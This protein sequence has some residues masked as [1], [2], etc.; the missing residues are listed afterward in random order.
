MSN[1]EQAL[2]RTIAYGHLFFQPLTLAEVRRYLIRGASDAPAF[3][4][5]AQILAAYRSSVVLQ[6]QIAYEGGFFYLK[7]DAGTGGT[8][9][10][11]AG[12]QRGWRISEQKLRRARKAAALFKYFPFVRYIGVANR[13][14]WH[15]AREE[16]DIDLFV[17]ACSGRL[18][19]VRA[20]VTGMAA[21]L[22]WRPTA[23]LSADK[24][25]LSFY[26]SD[27]ALGIESLS[28]DDRDIHFAFW[29][30]QVLPLVDY[31]QTSARFFSLN[32]PWLSRYFYRVEHE[33]YAR[34]VRAQPLLQRFFERCSVR[35]VA[36]ALERRLCRW[37]TK[38]LDQKRARLSAARA[39]DVVYSHQVI[40]L[41]WTDRRRQV[42]DRLE[43]FYEAHFSSSR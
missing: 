31:A 16:S 33:H 37:Q 39:T 29:T 43:S 26:V 14:G 36:D 9:A 40:K 7:Q 34:T 41:H 15:V 38:L 1:I 22:R 19:L 4:T 2:A 11:Q 30:Y 6:E 35:F 32:A 8:A 28:L 42:R 18:W 27:S 5:C 21:L 23:A 10:Q 20:M 3:V 24:L 13:V 12:R 25:C 17:V